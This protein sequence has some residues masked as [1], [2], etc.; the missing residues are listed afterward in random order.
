MMIRRRTLLQSTGL[1]GVAWAGL[2]SPSSAAQTF[3]SLKKS[4]RM[5]M[6]FVGHGSPMNAITDNDYL[7]GRGGH[8]AVVG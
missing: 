1:L 4:P 5:P 7:R 3:D 6:L 8:R 2:T